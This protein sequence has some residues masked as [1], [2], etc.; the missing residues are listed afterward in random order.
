MPDFHESS[1]TEEPIESTSSGGPFDL[2]NLAGEWRLHRKIIQQNGDTFSFIGKATLRWAS[3]W[4]KPT[5]NYYEQG[6]VTS[7]NGNIMSA[8]RRYFW[9]QSQR[10]FFDVLFDDKRYFH[11]FSISN[12]NAHHLCGDDHYVVHYRF[13]TWPLWCATWQVKGPR[14]YYTMVSEYSPL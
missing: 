11:S 6:E 1:E 13:E 4:E 2:K 5:L 3:G 14:K 8:E 7:P 10:G 9:Q 12:P